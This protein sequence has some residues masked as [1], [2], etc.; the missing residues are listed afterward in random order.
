M[1]TST[2]PIQ[3]PG[4]KGRVAYL[5]ANSSITITLPTRLCLVAITNNYYG[6]YDI[7]I[8]CM[9]TSGNTLVVTSLISATTRWNYE[10]VSATQLKITSG[11]Y[12]GSVSVTAIGE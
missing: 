7:L 2:I 8:V 3:R 1:A 9:K 6:N 5:A 4:Y 11:I 10:A 12:D